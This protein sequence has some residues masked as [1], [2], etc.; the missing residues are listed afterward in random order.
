M[1]AGL[2]GVYRVVFLASAFF[3]KGL[4]NA[5]GNRWRKSVADGA[6]Y[7]GARTQGREAVPEFGKGRPSRFGNGDWGNTNRT[8]SADAICV[9]HAQAVLQEMRAL[10]IGKATVDHGALSPWRERHASC[11]SFGVTA[12]EV[13]S[14]MRS[15]VCGDVNVSPRSTL[16]S[17]DVETP[18][19]SATSACFLPV[20][21]R[22][23]TSRMVTNWRN[24]TLLSSDN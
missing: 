16:E 3:M 10:R 6:H 12:P 17:W 15:A 7:S 18:I 11:R 5:A 4:L 24:T 1:F 23:S 14:M 21:C 20:I 22:H 8:D 13:K 19:A 2:G 9:R